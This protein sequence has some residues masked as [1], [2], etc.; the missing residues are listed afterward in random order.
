M[1][2]HELA[3]LINSGASAEEVHKA[4]NLPSEP[5]SPPPEPAVSESTYESAFAPEEPANR[6]HTAT[7]RDLTTEE[8]VKA[9]EAGRVAFD[10]FR[11]DTSKILKPD[12]FGFEDPVE[13]LFFL[14][15]DIASG[16]VKLHPWQIQI[17]QDFAKGGITDEFPFQALVRACNGSGKDKYVIAPCA[18]W[19]CMRYVMSRCVVTSAS[20]DQLDNQTDAYIYQ[21]CLAANRKINPNIWKL[22]YRYYECLATQ[23]PMKLFATDEP[24]KAEGYHPLGHGRKMAIF[25]S[26]AKSIP[27]EINVAINKCTG[28]THRVHVST[29]GPTVGH[30]YEYCQPDVSVRRETIKDI[31]EIRPIDY[32]QYHVTAFDCSHL[33]RN[34]VEQSKRDLPGGENGAAFKSQVLAEFGQNTSELVAIP[35]EF[36][37]SIIRAKVNHIPESFNTAGIDLADGGDET[38]LCVRNGNKQIFQ[39]PFKFNNTEDTVA[40]L[41]EKFREFG[42]DNPESLIFGDAGGI[43]KP[44]LDRLYRMGWRNIRYVDNRHTSSR[45]KIYKNKNSEIWFTIRKLF[46]RKEI[47]IINDR[48][49][50]KQLSN[51]HYK[52]VDGRVHQMWT[53]IE[54]KAKSKDRTSPDRADAFN[55]CFWN[56]KSIFVEIPEDHK[57]PFSTPAPAKPV[58]D[59]D[60]RV[61]AKQD[62]SRGTVKIHSSPKGK[63]FQLLQRDIAAWNK[64]VESQNAPTN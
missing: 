44:I 61:W 60:M 18:V 7:S 53:K 26:E 38:V 4:A 11:P 37:G 43:G 10:T 22:N 32:I 35:G 3:E 13:L 31:Y 27:D 21:L 17:M 50:I 12:G 62:D 23:S 36:V 39:D 1:T 49:L 54:E 46:E 16:L 8:R 41:N 56:Y 9:N 55:L 20:G 58:A 29:P 59:F 64:R 40:Y 2:P 47:I 51:R 19:L 52:I 33:S 14:D 45:P 57:A 48:L 42:L 6:L 63:E 34:Y 30:F 25:M 28:Y 24:G 15:D 5:K